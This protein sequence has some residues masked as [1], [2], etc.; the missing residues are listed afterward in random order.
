[1]AENLLDIAKRTFKA[2]NYQYALGGDGTTDSNRD[3]IEGVHCSGMVSSVLRH[4][5]Y[6]MPFPSKDRFNT[7]RE[8][9]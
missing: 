2:I 5:G 4:G 8:G 3:G 7:T 1:M 9:T 6:E